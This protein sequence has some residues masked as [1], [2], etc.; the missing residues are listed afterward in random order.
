MMKRLINAESQP[1]TDNPVPPRHV[2]M[3]EDDQSVAEAV[4]ERLGRENMIVHHTSSIERGRA[5][6]ASG[7]RFDA[8]VLDLGLP[9]GSGLEFATYCRKSGID[10]PIIMVTAVDG[11]NDRV[12]GLS[13]GADDYLCKPFAVEELYARIEALLRRTRASH[14][15][16]LTYADIELDLVTRRVRRRDRDTELSTR[17]LDLLAYLMC[18]PE[19]ALS[20]EQIVQNVWGD[21]D[22]Y[23]V[24]V[25]RVY[26]NYLRN[27]L[28]KPQIIYTLRGIGYMLSERD[29]EEFGVGGEFGQT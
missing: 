28:G 12:K 29:P 24:G 14:T 17:E 26:T 15:H 9:D 20:Q 4:R 27:K 7:R 16:L 22:F 25:L 21:T 5:I 19:E 23:E 3:I 2:L 10:T 13:V 11:V 18:H 1:K 6:V 8:I